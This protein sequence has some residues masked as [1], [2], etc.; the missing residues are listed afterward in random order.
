[1]KTTAQIISGSSL[2]SVEPQRSDE[3]ILSG[4]AE[5]SLAPSEGERAGVRGKI[6][7]TKPA[8]KLCWR[9]QNN[10]REPSSSP[11]LTPHPQSH[12]P[13]EGVREV[14]VAASFHFVAP[15]KTAKNL[16]F[17]VL[18]SLTICQAQPST[19]N[20][21]PNILFAIAD[22]WSAG[23]AGAYGCRWVK[24]PAFD[25]V[26][27][28]GLLFT[29]AYTPT[30]KCSPSR[31]A[32]LTGRNP[33]QLAAAANHVSYFPPEFKTWAEAL[34]ENGYI[35][36]MTGKGWGPGVATNQSG[37]EREMTG[38]PFNERRALPLTSGIKSNDYAANFNQF[39]ESTSATKP[40]CFW[41]GGMEPHRIYEQGSGVSKGGKK[42]SDI[43]YVPSQWPDSPGVRE[44][45]LDYAFEVEHFDRHLGRMLNLL[46]ARGLLSNT[47]VV[48]TSDN[49]MP[50]PRAKGQAYEDSDHMPLAI[51]WPAGIQ[52]PGR[53]VSEFVSF[54]DFAP[55][56]IELAGIKW[57]QT[58]MAAATGRS[59]T[60]IFSGND[61]V[62]TKTPRDHLIIGRER[63]DVGRPH[64]AGYPVR[65]IVNANF[66]YLHN[67]E[68]T[69]WPS[70]NAE[71]GY[72]DACGCQTK[73]EILSNRATPEQRRRWELTFGLRGAE[74]LY[75]RSRDPHCLTNLAS[76]TAFHTIKQQLREQLFS[77]LRAQN[78]PR[79]LG[80]GD[81]FDQYPFAAE[82]IRGFYERSQRGEKLNA[83]WINASDVEVSRN[84]DPR[85][86]GNK[87]E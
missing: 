50:F 41:Y 51:Q 12:T 82:G 78:D 71:T 5:F 21:R 47:I 16:F 70:G 27:K 81:V 13:S 61:S 3:N 68:P 38:K 73:T 24:T 80:Q 34:G 43:D 33:W 86:G 15:P 53:S 85:V 87:R 23:H 22:D 79:A 8:S 77:A 10:I 6:A 40:W 18:L 32:I 62:K 29:R 46:E 4:G 84:S 57:Q 28:Q 63:N 49:G 60:D 7:I 69:R 1:M 17:A 25:R 36:G 74:E 42:L 11:S 37:Q 59:L 58:G 54:I 83:P 14:R 56:I 44:D 52:R 20:T 30:A 76:D 31:S 35:V 72:T 45:L 75:H 48:V 67:F 19:T 66:R 2:F 64:D 55:T 39:L 26:A 9:N 65:G